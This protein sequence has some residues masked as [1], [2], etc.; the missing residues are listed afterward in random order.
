MLKATLEL[1]YINKMEKDL[2]FNV[3][4]I[5]KRAKRVLNFKIDA[6]LAAYL[7]VSRSTLSN[8]IARNSIGRN[9]TDTPASV[10]SRNRINF[11]MLSSAVPNFTSVT[12][13][14]QASLIPSSAFLFSSKTLSANTA[15]NSSEVIIMLR[16]PIPEITPKL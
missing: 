12:L 15:N 13:S 7:G 1:I 14:F 11:P 2:F 5:V 8:W 16:H 3:A 10:L 9:I 6:D 4:D